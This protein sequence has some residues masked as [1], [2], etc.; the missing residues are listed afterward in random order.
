VSFLAITIPASLLLAAAL[1]AL[2]IRHVRAGDFDD[3]DAPATR[4]HHDDDATPELEAPSDPESGARSEPTASEDHWTR[5]AGP[6]AP[7]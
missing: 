2:V 3:L 7:G 1:L 4:L 6:A 5:R